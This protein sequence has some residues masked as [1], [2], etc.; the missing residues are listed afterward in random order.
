MR[1]C[2]LII[3]MLLLFS[4]QSL[5]QVNPFLPQNNNADTAVQ[6]TVIQESIDQESIDQ[7]SKTPNLSTEIASKTPF[8][9]TIIDIQKELHG[10][11]SSLMKQL[12]EDFSITHLI[13]FLVASFVYGVVHSTGPGHAKLLIG[14]KLLSSNHKKRDALKAGSLFAFTH[15]GVALLLFFVVT[16][17]LKMSSGDS[18]HYANKMISVSAVMIIITAIYLIVDV[19]ND[20]RHNDHDDT[21]TPK[22]KSLFAL[23]IFAGLSP[24][25]GALLILIFS[26]LL[27]IVH[28]GVAA[29]IAVSLGMAL[30]VSAIGFFTVMGRETIQKTVKKK[31][32]ILTIGVPMV[33]ISGAVIIL[34]IGWSFL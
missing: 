4:T 32:A 28:Y 26:N 8:L 5:S 33:R 29:V 7:E 10:K 25:P 19:I 13:I 11:I 12:K 31:Q 2:L 21:D 30:T 34:L 9:S 17:I 14:S 1:F 15:T 6:D 24:C 23:A 16:I 20:I 27:G 3:S 18:N 22:S